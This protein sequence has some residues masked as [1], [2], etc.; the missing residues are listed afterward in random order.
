MCH[1]QERESY[2]R[3]SQKTYVSNYS[4]P[5]ITHCKLVLD[6]SHVALSLTVTNQKENGT[7]SKWRT[8]LPLTRLVN[9]TMETMVFFLFL[10]LLISNCIGTRF[11]GFIIVSC[12]EDIW[13]K[14]GQKCSFL[15]EI[16]LSPIL[17]LRSQMA[18]LEE[19]SLCVSFCILT[20]VQKGKS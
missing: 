2:S 9:F 15:A 6:W 12:S 17:L 1:R 8:S 5:Y 19:R 14:V 11:L 4:L 16:P 7:V 13:R 3:P 18:K 20:I 10:I